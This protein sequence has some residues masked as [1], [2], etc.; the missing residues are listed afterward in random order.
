MRLGKLS[1]LVGVIFCTLVFFIGCSDSTSS[2]IQ[3]ADI[4]DEDFVP[5]KAQIDTLLT[6]MVFDLGQGFSNLYVVP[7]DEGN[8]VVQLGPAALEPDPETDP[9]SLFSSYS[10][11][12]Y[13]VYADYTSS[14]YSVVIEDSVQ[15]LI[16]DTP[17]EF[18]ASADEV[19]FIENYEFTALE[20]TETHCDYSG[21]SD[22]NFS[23]LDTD[24][25]TIGGTAE[26][27]RSVY[28]VS[29]D[30]SLTSVYNFDAEYTNLQILKYEN[31]SCNCPNAGMATLTMT[32]GT[33]WDFDGD[34]GTG[35][36][37]WTITV[38][39][40]AGT[41]TV[42]ASDGSSTWRYTCDVC[43]VNGTI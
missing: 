5:V 7:G 26:H 2:G 34:T 10:N 42:T 20:Q 19:N 15:Y 17:V 16:D 23:D 24:I 38:V 28:W 18:D 27:D 40:D 1:A 30:S 12:W 6:E 32:R 9:D 11:G 14:V 39:F 4:D 8:D 13:Y 22:F 3:Y 21:R 36:T 37:S 43:T 33:S 25:A 35:N 41:A 31:W 29:G